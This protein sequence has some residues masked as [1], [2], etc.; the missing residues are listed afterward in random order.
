MKPVVPGARRSSAPGG[1]MHT[2]AHKA[3]TFTS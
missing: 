3:V 2:S 1:T